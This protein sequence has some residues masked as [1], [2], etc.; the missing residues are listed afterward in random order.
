MRLTQSNEY[1]NCFVNCKAFY[2][3]SLTICKRINEKAHDECPGTGW[4][5]RRLEEKEWPQST[6][7]DC[8]RHRKTVCQRYMNKHETSS[9]PDCFN[10][11]PVNKVDR[12]LLV[13]LR[14]EKPS[15]SSCPA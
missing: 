6:H 15:P 4:R 10:C 1:E 5:Q 13:S 14:Q 12:Q 9:T 7:R 8:G 3:C 11:A 2:G